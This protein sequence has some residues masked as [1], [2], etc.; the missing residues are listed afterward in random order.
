MACGLWNVLTTFLLS[1]LVVAQGRPGR[2]A[3]EEGVHYH[4]YLITYRSYCTEVPT[5]GR[6]LPCTPATCA[7]LCASTNSEHSHLRCSHWTYWRALATCSILS[8]PAAHPAR[9]AHP[10]CVSGERP[11]LGT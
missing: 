6:P 1:L 9:L 4:G 2:T 8:S 5:T 10:S 11:T 7:A 3:I